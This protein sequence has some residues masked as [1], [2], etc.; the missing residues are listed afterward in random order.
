MIF[1]FRIL[2]PISLLIA[3]FLS[4][5]LPSFP[6]FFVFLWTH[7]HP[8]YVITLSRFPAFSLL[9]LLLYSVLAI[10]TH[11]IL[12]ILIE[13]GVLGLDSLSGETILS[14]ALPRYAPS[15]WQGLRF[16]LPHV[17]VSVSILLVFLSKIPEHHHFAKSFFIVAWFRRRRQRQR[18]ELQQ[19][20]P[21]RPPAVSSLEEADVQPSQ[22]YG[23]TPTG[24]I[25]HFSRRP[26][27]IDVRTINLS[28]I[29]EEGVNLL[30]ASD[31]TI[32][33]VASSIT[34]DDV[35]IGATHQKHSQQPGEPKL[36]KFVAYMAGRA[37]LFWCGISTWLVGVSYSS[38]CTFVFISVFSMVALFGAFH[39]EIVHPRVNTARCLRYLRCYRVFLTTY[40]VLLFCFQLPWL[41][42]WADPQYGT[43]ASVLQ[44]IGLVPI[45]ASK[46]TG[47]T[48]ITGFSAALVTYIFTGMF[49]SALRIVQESCNL[50]DGPPSRGNTGPGEATLEA[51][52][53]TEGREILQ[54]PSFYELQLLLTARH[55]SSLGLLGWALVFP[56]IL[57]LPLL[58]AAILYLSLKNYRN[59]RL[60]QY[61]IVY[62]LILQM[63]HFLLIAVMDAFRAVEDDPAVMRLLGL[64]SL[65]VS[66][67]VN[68]IES[69]AFG[70]LCLNLFSRRHIEIIQA[71]SDHTTTGDVPGQ[72]QIRDFV[73]MSLFSSQSRKRDSLYSPLKLCVDQVAL[74]SL[75]VAGGLD[76]TELNS[77]FLGALSILCILQSFGL[78]RRPK[79]FAVVWSM[80]L[81]YSILF[82]LTTGTFCRA[83]DSVWECSL[84]DIGVKK[85]N[86]GQVVAYAATVV[87]ASVQVNYTW[88]H[89]A[90][91]R[92]EEFDGRIWRALRSYFLYVAYAA[93]LFYPLL[94]H[95]NFLSYGH[96][97]FLFLTLLVELLPSSLGGQTPTAR[98]VIKKYWF[99]VV[100][101]TCAGML[102]RYF[103]SLHWSS[104]SQ[105]ETRRWLFGLDPGDSTFV[106]SLGDAIL[107]IIVSLQGRFF[108]VDYFATQGKSG[109]RSESSAPDENTVQLSGALDNRDTISEPG[110]ARSPMEQDHDTLIPKHRRHK[111]LQENLTPEFTSEPLSWL[112]SP[113]TGPSEGGLLRH[114][115]INDVSEVH[116][117]TSRE[118]SNVTNESERMRKAEAEER[119]RNELQQ[120]LNRERIE[121]A[122]DMFR[123]FRKSVPVKKT[124]QFLQSTYVSLVMLLR[125]VMLKYSYALEAVAILAASIWLPGF[126]VFGALYIFL[127]CIVLL[128]EQPAVAHE[129]DEE[130]QPGQRISKSM[131]SV[132]LILSF[133]LMSAQYIFL[134]I[135]QMKDSSDG[136]VTSYVGLQT[137][138]NANT[139]PI[140][141][142]A[143]VAHVLVFITAI[144][145]KI[146]VR[147]A[148]M[149]AGSSM[150]RVDKYANSLRS[151]R[152]G[153]AENANA[154]D[155][156][157]PIGSVL[158]GVGGPV[159][160]PNN[161][162]SGAQSSFVTGYGA[163]W[164]ET[165]S[166]RPNRGQTSQLRQVSNNKTSALEQLSEPGMEKKSDQDRIEQVRGKVS[167]FVK[168]FS[169]RLKALVSLLRP[170]WKDWGSDVTFMYLV[171]C[172]AI[173]D[174]VFSIVYVGI[175]L[176][177][178]GFKRKKL[179]RHWHQISLFLVILVLMQ[180]VLTLGLP[181]EMDESQ[182]SD[183]FQKWRVWLLLDRDNNSSERKIAVTFAFIA[184]ICAAI[185][186]NSISAGSRGFS[187][188]FHKLQIRNLVGREESLDDSGDEEHFLEGLEESERSSDGSIR[189]SPDVSAPKPVPVPSQSLGRKVVQ[190]RFTPRTA[191]SSQRSVDISRGSSAENRRIDV[192]GVSLSH[193]NM[194]SNLEA[195]GV[196]KES[197]PQPR[198]DGK[199]PL[200]PASNEQFLSAMTDDSLEGSDS[201][202]IAKR[203][204]RP[205]DP[206]DFTRRPISFPNAVK[207][208]WMRLMGGFVQLYVF[209]VA[210]V[211]TN[212]ISAILLVVALSFLFQFT[213]I[214]AKKSRF[215]FLRGYV[216]AVVFL[217]V[218]FQAP[219]ERSGDGGWEDILG[220]YSDDT[221]RGQTML[222][223][224]VSLWIVCQVQ[225]RIYESRDFQYVERYGHEDAKVRFKRAVHEHNGRKY[226]KLLDRNKA[227]RSNNARKARLTRLKA[228]KESEKTVDAF[229]N[230]CVVH[231][232]DFLRKQ[233]KAAETSASKFSSHCQTE[234]PEDD[235]KLPQGINRLFR[236]FLR[237]KRWK[238]Y[239][240]QTLSAE[241][242]AFIFRYSA[243]PVYGTMVF[244][245]IINP[246]IT[247]IAYPVV[248]FL[249]L[250]VEQPRPPKHAWTALMVYVCC[251]IAF[252]YGFRSQYIPFCS[253]G[254]PFF[255]IT[256][257]DRSVPSLQNFTDCAPAAGIGFDIFI[258]LALLGHRAVL[259]SR[260]VWDLVMSEE[261]MLLRSEIRGHELDTAPEMS[262]SVES[263]STSAGSNSNQ[264][265]VT[266]ENGIVEHTWSAVQ[267][268]DDVEHVLSQAR[269]D[270]VGDVRG[271]AKVTNR[272][273]AGQT[274]D[275]FRGTLK[276]ENLRSKASPSPSASR[277]IARAQYEQSPL[278]D[279]SGNMDILRRRAAAV[280]HVREP[281]QSRNMPR[282]RTGDS[283][284]F[285][286][287]AP[288]PTG[289]IR[290]TDPRSIPSPQESDLHR[291]HQH[292]HRFRSLR[293]GVN[294][295]EGSFPPTPA[296][297][298][299]G[300]SRVQQS[301][302][303][304]RIIPEFK[305][306]RGR[307]LT[308]FHDEQKGVL[309]SLRQYFVRMTRENDHKAVGD[310]Y[311]LIFIVD[312]ISFVYVMFGYS[313]I[314]GDSTSGREETWWTTNFIETQHLLTLLAMFMMIILDRIC[315]LTRSMTGKLILHYSSV[316]GYH[317]VLFVVEDHIGERIAT[318]IF[319]ILRCIYF[320]LSGL[321]IRDGF[322]MYTTAQ[323]LLRNYT[324][325]GIVLFEIYI[326]VPF[327]WLSRT[328]LD[329]TVLPTS[330]E[331]F[332]YFRFID[333]YLWLY[334]NRTVNASRGAFRRR[335]GEKRRL[336]PR[337]YQGFGLF[338][339]CVIAL[340]L[341]FI[342]FSIFNPFVV[343]RELNDAQV[344]V[345][346]VTFEGSSVSGGKTYEIYSRTSAVGEALNRDQSSEAAG[347]IG[348]VLDV[349]EREKVFEA[350]F[351]AVSGNTWQV[352]DEDEK[353]LVMSLQTYAT[354]NS[355]GAP[356]L[357]DFSLTATTQD[358]MTFGTLGRQHTYELEK[359]QA[360][361]IAIA[362]SEKLDFAMKIR[363]P[364]PRYSIL[365]SGAA[366]FRSYSGQEGFGDV[367][368]RLFQQT[369]S[370]D[371]GLS[372]WT[373]SDASGEAS[374]CTSTTPF[375]ETASRRRHLLQIADISNL[376]VGGATILTLYTA[377]LFTIAN[378]LKRMFIDKR[379]IIPYIDMPY[380][381][382]LYQ[383]A[384]DIMYARQDNQLEMEEILYNG[385]IDIYRDQHE[386]VRWAGERALK[387]PEAWWDSSEVDNPFM[388][389]PSFSETAAEPYIDRIVE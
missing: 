379:L 217:L 208:N 260:G 284:L 73:Q 102:S 156:A 301:L 175:V 257:A 4:I 225:G 63:V 43:T 128:A 190:Q 44:L 372:F 310:Y 3:S 231:E 222:Y 146:A 351:S 107:L 384:L 227:E 98:R 7:Y 302:A 313:V 360:E 42:R 322:P 82:L 270:I 177:I 324:T 188:W 323:F 287:S 215:K 277:M 337:V 291:V 105:E 248:V 296:A 386:L 292:L 31:Q 106:I 213:N 142:E 75:Y 388:V 182:S 103:V 55:A 57:T 258:L 2:L 368:I 159:Q 120:V 218:I 49:E 100:V 78:F 93:L 158:K 330:L 229:Y 34:N 203:L 121:Q 317:I 278:R 85:A 374:A 51:N 325:L 89:T 122:L 306:S 353:D 308:L 163:S 46:P 21:Q 161:D 151:T 186:L 58:F 312:F 266:D 94:Y 355:T 109:D 84:D 104:Q 131:P 282:Q 309:S 5:S 254:V 27:E 339:L 10:A 66:F 359:S 383:L 119:R 45:D 125:S 357:L 29:N 76:L 329:W 342:I 8:A 255:E 136:L 167:D 200:F 349:R 115:T 294:K 321:Q 194:E 192:D 336:L 275:H 1:R 65:R 118:L 40:V 123:N 86:T 79:L 127:G 221:E 375:E 180:Y 378:L 343:G 211:D 210:T 207:L 220:L 326:F 199:P 365:Q 240:S 81:V 97:I 239:I 300:Q 224:L 216:I 134:I 59:S 373:M 124:E 108:A 332:Q 26:R 101:F 64:Q 389:Y 247:T 311:L 25:R 154:L 268:C 362:L 314:F 206:R 111:S 276:N 319:Y 153:P 381:L 62:A 385:L 117:P 234:T 193:A 303:Q 243:W 263:R 289:A 196:L 166:W 250:I 201:D 232:I 377:I 37:G 157:V 91:G 87:L 184:V 269:K 204:L 187:Y 367:C 138:L 96:V 22:H 223:L 297:M 262:C 144:V 253:S 358:R 132:L 361:Q 233:A 380:T 352:P 274:A 280:R 12:A 80:V 348:V 305:S 356:P 265:S 350:L 371:V 176:V 238:H 228:L 318:Q 148:R 189:D 17:L 14:L 251:V 145:Q 28:T 237:G 382:H 60:F 259:Y 155:S 341:P 50:E 88:S 197:N 273:Q 11:I 38:L 331:I 328:L 295:I 9:L 315:Y 363:A 90:E 214:A 48:A 235:E 160:P 346:L 202:D 181:S 252:K 230:V 241:M 139:L 179:S 288:P 364:L 114:R 316:I 47:W 20:Q 307:N 19:G 333:I 191:E 74:A 170:F 35:R 236:K 279:R 338:L 15:P 143:M 152:Q 54:K 23:R 212:V 99:L 24:L 370:P 150:K 30:E 244:A 129:G 52:V 137:P 272:G 77:V 285:P 267:Q 135:L 95:A 347:A 61:L 246:S 70:L 205:N 112:D 304:A 387:L 249:Y 178:G 293:M 245:A 327:L 320:L 113:R 283:S 36:T 41:V 264:G 174:T 369:G 149:D 286:M 354:G 209:A 172:G 165:S 344:N 173:T 68:L 116:R 72:I 185:T 219:F 133:S 56:G 67:S 140:G 242:K 92:I 71:R 110:D 13:T 226:E 130:L 366:A 299:S 376:Q 147:W 69:I 171:I 141:M 6:Y 335:L 261:D 39:I 169:N 126:S 162:V 164:S 334:R 168:H 16:L 345:N 340:F 271:Q 298:T 195:G 198:V 256:A 32:S 183:S 53:E 290:G 83:V 18:H 33:D 281:E